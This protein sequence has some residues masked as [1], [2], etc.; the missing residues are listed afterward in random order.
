MPFLV[1]YPK[2]IKAGTKTDA[3]VENVDFAPTML[4]YAGVKR[5]EVMQG[6]SFRS[7]LD[8]GKEPADWK[9]AAY[10]R[11][12]MHMA[13]HD[14]PGH[15]GIRTKQYKLLFYYGC[16][17]KGQ[18]RTPPG[19]ELYDLKKD[20]LEVVNEYDNPR[21]AGVVADLKARLAA[22]RRRVGDTGQDYPEVE[23]IIREFW[24]YDA[25]ARKKAEQI[26]HDYLAKKT[27]P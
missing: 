12:W 7:I 14:N 20:P 5:P 11:Y 13:H 26:S 17:Y 19:W 18:N 23:A 16:D 3:I 8:T 22:L 1:R 4:D 25:G 10:Y 21:Y 9:K 27:A 6:R 24:D 2:C 15:V